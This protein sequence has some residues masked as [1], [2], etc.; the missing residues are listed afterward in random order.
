MSYLLRCIK[1][2]PAGCSCFGAIA[3]LVRALPC[4]GRGRGFESRWSR[5]EKDSYVPYLVHV[6]CPSIYFGGTMSTKK[7]IKKE[8]IT[9]QEEY[10]NRDRVALLVSLLFVLAIFVFGYR[11]FNNPTSRLYRVVNSIQKDFSR[12]ASRNREIISSS[13]VRDDEDDIALDDTK[14]DLDLSGTSNQTGINGDSTNTA[15]TQETNTTTRTDDTASSEGTGFLAKF[16]ESI[17]IDTDDSTERP[18]TS[19][20]TSGSE[21]TDSNNG[22]TVQYKNT[23]DQITFHE[24]TQFSEY[25]TFGKKI[26]DYKHG[27]IKSGSYV[28]QDGDTLWEIAEAVYGNGAQW[29]QILN[30]N[31]SSIGHLP[32]GQQAL[33]WSGQTL[34]IP[35]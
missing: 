8:I 19:S 3:Q 10:N 27:D 30:A 17:S 25:T 24:D 31:S 32:S 12:I 21:T 14:K 6:Y 23:N 7:T 35:M 15:P 4:H 9:E 22:G 20:T 2:L 33:I 34:N 11:Y 26:N 28:V 1:P 29:T 5:Q 18:G 16:K 13:T